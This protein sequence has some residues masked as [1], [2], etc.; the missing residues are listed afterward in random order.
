MWYGVGLMNVAR[1]MMK[2]VGSIS[3]GK[4]ITLQ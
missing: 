2:A 4:S 3:F 1:D